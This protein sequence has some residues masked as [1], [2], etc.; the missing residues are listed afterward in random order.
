MYYFVFQLYPILKSLGFILFF[1]SLSS[2]SNHDDLYCG[3]FPFAVMQ[4]A[5]SLIHGRHVEPWT[6]LIVHQQTLQSSSPSPQSGISTPPCAAV[7][8]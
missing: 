6:Y 4:V 3:N 7:K 5:V 2:S 8:L 1:F